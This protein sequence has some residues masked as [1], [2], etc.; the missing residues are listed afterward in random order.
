MP[1]NEEALNELRNALPH[2]G[3]SEVAKR[4]GVSK[5]IVNRVLSGK[6]IRPDVIEAAQALVDE[7]AQKIKAYN[8]KLQEATARAAAK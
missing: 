5:Y 6:A 4:V 8:E 7:E 3:Q 1:I 2:G